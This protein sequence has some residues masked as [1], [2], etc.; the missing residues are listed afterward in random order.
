MLAQLGEVG[1]EQSLLDPDTLAL[2]KQPALDSASLGTPAA[3]PRMALGL[4]DE[5][6]GGHRIV[7]H[8]GD[9]D[10]FHSHMQL[11]PDDR[12]GVF[13]TLNSAGRGAADTLEL[14]QSL[15]EGFADRYFP[16]ADTAPRQATSTAASHAAQAE[17][18][19]ESARS[20]FSTFLTAMGLLGQTRVTARAD[21]TVLIEPGP[22]SPYPAVY[23]EIEPWVWQEVG[24]Q[25]I[26]TMRT[27]GDRVEALGFESAF[28]LLRAAP[29]RDAGI[30]LPVLLSSAA[31]LIVGLLAW[32]IGAIV[33]RRYRLPAPPRI[34][35]VARVLTR[36]AAAAALLALGGWAVAVLT[37]VGLQ[38]V[39]E[40]LIRVLQGAQWVAVLGVLPATVALVASVR[41]R[42]GPIRIL[43]SVF[44]LLSLVGLGWFAQAFGLLS[45]DVSY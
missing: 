2:M 33:R 38:D 41:H 31:V 45:L 14:R 9:T 40:P 17:G 25:R 21:G 8:G 27:A 1:P 13:V 29:A 10:F 11:Y 12:T 39:P 4:F 36:I 6:R 3:G 7:G 30:V 20:P 23:R 28:T 15:L 42:S 37:I 32:P 24:G 43:G 18:S 19:Y 5:S 34:G 22:M 44:V 16:A 35:R 26:V